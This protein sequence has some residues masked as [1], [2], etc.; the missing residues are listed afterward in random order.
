MGMMLVKV[1]D[2]QKSVWIAAIFPSASDLLEV[3]ISL[4]PRA[5]FQ[6]SGLMNRLLESGSLTRQCS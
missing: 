1:D 6:E 5:K 2:F 4:A 3:G